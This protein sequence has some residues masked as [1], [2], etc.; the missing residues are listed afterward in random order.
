MSVLVDSSK[1]RLSQ[2]V[3][4][5]RL[6]VPKLAWSSLGALLLIGVLAL[7]LA[8]PMVLLFVK[9]FIVSRPGQPAVWTIQGWIEAFSDDKLPLALGNTFFLASLRV[10]VTTALAIFFAWVVSP[11]GHTL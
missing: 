3:V 1:T 7:L 4:L 5:R 9:S 10:A 6:R 11:H 8:Y 2:P